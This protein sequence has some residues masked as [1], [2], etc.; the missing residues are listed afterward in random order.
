MT[1]LVR[2]AT[3]KDQH[4][5]HHN[6]QRDI[7]I[8]NGVVSEISPKIDTTADHVI[9]AEGLCLSP[10][11]VDIFVAGN[12][13]GFEFKDDLNSTAASAAKGGFTH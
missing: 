11:W 12:D 10:G 1:I 3:I 4:S 8:S 13:P 5:S 9:E 2:K 6:Q 7:L